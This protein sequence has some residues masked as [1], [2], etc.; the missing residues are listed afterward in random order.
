VLSVPA[1]GRAGVARLLV[2]VMVALM[3]SASDAVA[4]V[5]NLMTRADR[6][7]LHSPHFDEPDPVR[8]PLNCAA[9]PLRLFGFETKLAPSDSFSTLHVRVLRYVE[10]ELG[11]TRFE[12]LLG[13]MVRLSHLIAQGAV[14]E[15]PIAAGFVGMTDEAGAVSLVARPGTYRLQI[16]HLGFRGGQGLVRIRPAASDSL[17]AYVEV[18]AIC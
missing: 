9:R 3:G 18:A 12:P 4:Q 7:V 2:I 13:T 17:R 5:E 6:I 8:G 11:T 1:E 10:P 16:G 14:N 15:L